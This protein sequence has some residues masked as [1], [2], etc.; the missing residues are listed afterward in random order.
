[1]ALFQRPQTSQSLSGLLPLNLSPTNHR[2]R[3][4][5]FVHKM[6]VHKFGSYLTP[7]LLKQQRDGIPLNLY[8]KTSNRLASTLPELRTKLSRKVSAEIRGEFFRPNFWVNFA[9][10]SFFCDFFGPFS[11]KKTRG[12]NRWSKWAKIEVQMCVCVC[13]TVAFWV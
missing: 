13:V 12:K 3:K 1:M 8:E 2:F 9:G 5:Q 4:R 7:P 11:L 10:E 6:F